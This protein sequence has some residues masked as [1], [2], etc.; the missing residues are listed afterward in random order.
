MLQ[1]RYQWRVY[2]YGIAWD[3][4]KGEY[5]VTRLPKNLRLTV[6]AN[7]VE[8]AMERALEDATDHV[9]FLIEGTQQILAEITA[10]YVE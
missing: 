8:H 9:G 5:D 4:G 2:L 6:D 10:E 7:D 1:D 3:D